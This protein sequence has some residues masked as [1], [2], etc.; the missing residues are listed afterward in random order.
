VGELDGDGEGAR[1]QGFK[2]RLGVGRRGPDADMLLN[3]LVRTA[4]DSDRRMQQRQRRRASPSVR[5]RRPS[6][7]PRTTSGAMRRQ[8][9]TCR[10]RLP[11]LVYTSLRGARGRAR[12]HTRRALTRGLLAT[13]GGRKA[14]GRGGGIAGRA[15]RDDDAARPRSLSRLGG[16]SAR[17]HHPVHP[18]GGICVVRGRLSNQVSKVRSGCPNRRTL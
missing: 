14:G 11:L 3:M 12:A 6:R 9:V 5:A 2:F 10:Q 16:K 1:A 15:A 13:G 17:S 8:K 18:A 7:A 4:S